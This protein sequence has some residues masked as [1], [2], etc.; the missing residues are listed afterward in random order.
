MALLNAAEARG[1]F[2][3]RLIAVYKEQNMPTGFLR[4]FFPSKESSSLNISIEVMRGFEKIAVDIERGSRGNGNKFSKSTEKIFQPPLY[5]EYFNA[6]DLD[7]YDRLFSRSENVDLDPITFREWLD[8]VIEKLVILRNKIERA[9][10]VQCSQVLDTG[11]VTLTSGDNVDFKRQ[12]SSKIVIATKWDVSTNPIA[13][14][15]TGCTFIRTEGKFSGGTITGIFGEDALESLIN[16][17]SFQSRADIKDYEL[18]LIRE[19]QRN[20]EGATLHGRVTAGAYK[21]NIWTYPQ[22]FTN[23]GGT[24]TPYIDTKKVILLP[25]LP[26][27]VLGFAGVPMSMATGNTNIPTTIA[28]ARGSYHVGEYL[29]L[30]K[31]THEFDVQS[32]GLAVPVAVDQVYTM[33]VLS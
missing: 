28:P 15:I 33:Q 23:S 21:I 22:F 32:A 13:D 25:E 26:N 27:F 1:L 19:P 7:F 8:T 16:N 24:A 10:E 30:R 9:Y 3:K 18:G 31:A 20:A 17:S 6:V 5:R 11:I 14:L 29:D 4:S 12:A 2:T